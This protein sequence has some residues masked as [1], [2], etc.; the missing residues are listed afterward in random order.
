M[1]FNTPQ[2]ILFL[3]IVVLVY[4]C[5]P[6]KIRYIWLLI[7][8][9]YFYMQWN[10]LYVTLL[11]SCTFLTYLCGRLLAYFSAQDDRKAEA[12]SDT[13]KKFCFVVCILLNLGIL[14]FFKYFQF[15]LSILNRLLS[16]A[17]IGEISWDYDILL[18]VGISFYTLQALGYLIDVY[19]GDI[20]AEKNFLRYALFVSFFPQLVAGPIER[21]Q[22]LLEQLHTPKSFSYENIRKGALLI[23]YGLFCKMVIADR[24]AIIVDT[25]YQD[26]ATY[27]GFYVV[28][29]T[30]LFSIQIYCDFYGYS[31]IARGSALLMGI[32][33]MDNFNAPYYARSV[34]EFWR[35]WHISLSGWF[36]DYLYIPLGGNRKGK[37]RKRGNLL[38]VFAVSGLWHG[39]S[40][41]FVCWGIL[42]GVYQVIEDLAEEI[43]ERTRGYWQKW[44]QMIGEKG[45]HTEQRFSGKLFRMIGTF[46]L[47]S[48]AWLFFRAGELDVAGETL[49]NLF[50]VN[51]WTIFFDG[52][53]Y[54]L[55][56]TQNG[57][58]VLFGA[59][60]LL[61]VVDYHKYH[62]KDVAD[63]FL[64]QGWWF[65]VL[66][67][68]G[69]LFMILLYGCYGEMYDIQQFI[70]FQF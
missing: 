52:S 15:G 39:A 38:V 44:Q 12:G 59:I 9:Y 24:A 66:G 30:I 23:L 54:E 42:N 27:P 6:K 48:F 65:R 25:V 22:N 63:V 28:M 40:L 3:P 16:F 43:K 56:V 45:E 61:F 29:A 53:L 18:P 37:L 47:V 31:T 62:G 10:P 68:M 11:F 8:S 20:Y 67:I 41:A 21:S 1:L 46:L 35:R 17:H 57:L 7:T 14:G 32:Q 4:Y 36:R 55:G 58:N 70:Y 49:T 2:Y 5:L 50:R 19:R 51:N 26:S 60:A 13:K 69:L 64:R 34:K 33:L